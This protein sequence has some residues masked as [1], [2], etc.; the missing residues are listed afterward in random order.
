M[1]WL[2]PDDYCL[3][4]PFPFHFPVETGSVVTKVEMVALVDDTDKRYRQLL[5]WWM[6]ECYWDHVI[7]KPQS[8]PEEFARV[9]AEIKDIELQCA[10]EI[11]PYCCM[12]HVPNGCSPN[13]T[14][15]N[16]IGSRYPPHI[17][18]VFHN[19][20]ENP[21]FPWNECTGVWK[22]QKQS[23]REMLVEMKVLAPV[24][25][26]KPK[27]KKYQTVQEEERHGIDS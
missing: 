24:P 10:S 4:N 18:H 19:A 2:D 1:T 21:R 12:L 25:K 20:P 23:F 13:K 5:N 7:G 27:L 14:D 22:G 26:V 11:T 17:Q 3:P 15:F 6:I 16:W 9:V 8:A